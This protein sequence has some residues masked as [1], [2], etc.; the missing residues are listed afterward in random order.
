M[1]GEGGGD[2]VWRVER[3]VS[4]VV[5]GGRF[6]E[7][8]EG[9]GREE[10]EG[11]GSKEGRG[12]RGRG[13]DAGGAEGGGYEVCGDGIGGGGGFGILD[14]FGGEDLGLHRV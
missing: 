13:T 7:E 3:G 11:S 1:G 5:K 6:G 8:G 9:V 4:G 14:G 12:G 2:E 10:M